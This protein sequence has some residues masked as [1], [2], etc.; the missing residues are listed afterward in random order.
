MISEIASNYQQNGTRPDPPPRLTL[1]GVGADDIIR[2]AEDVQ[3]LFDYY[4]R[5]PS[6][7]PVVQEHFLPLLESL[8]RLSSAPNPAWETLLLLNKDGSPKQEVGTISL[9]LEHQSPWREGFWFDSVRGTPMIA[10]KA[11]DD[12]MIMDIARWLSGT[13]RMV[14]TNLKLIGE[15]CSALCQAQPRDL[16][17]EWLEELPPW[18]QHERLLYWLQDTAEAP[19]TTYCREVSRLLPVSM[20]ARALHPGCR[21]RYVVMLEGQECTGKSTLVRTLVTPEW[22]YECSDNIEGKDAYIGIQGKWVAELP[23]LHA[24]SKTA[25][26]RFKGFITQTEDTWVPK[27]SNFSITRPRRTIFIGTLNPEGNQEYMR[28][29]TGN[30]RY[31]PVPTGQITPDM[32][33]QCRD[34]LFAEAL[35]YYR[36]HM[37]DWWQLSAE[38]EAEVA[39]LREDR[40]VSSIYEDEL[41]LWLGTRRETTWTE[42]AE[43]FLHLAPADWK[44]K[45][46]Q[47]QIAQALTGI[48]WQRIV[49][50][51]GTRVQR[52]WVCRESVT[53]SAEEVTGGNASI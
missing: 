26:N 4:L 7:A 48:G 5:K 34:Q 23:E 53:T 51:T 32:L 35:V 33:V 30:T 44:D 39:Q 18:D 31:L 12:L 22:L 11:L 13:A 17:R 37:Q 9:L 45:G 46:L 15:C 38:A 41:R 28:G 16:L 52:K 36:A 42:L 27:Y 24:M 6:L 29:Q 3:A 25:E 10:A 20:V 47:M 50:R 40:R 2:A 49:Q 43:Q 19:G 14:V 8:R 1:D 21:Y